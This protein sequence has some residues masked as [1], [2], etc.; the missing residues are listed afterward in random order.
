MRLYYSASDIFILPSRQ[1]N[2]PGTGIESHACGTPVVAFNTGGLPEIIDHRVT[3]A[4][5]KCF[6][7]KSLALEIAFVLECPERHASLKKASR[8]RAKLIWNQKRI[9]SMYYDLYSQ[10]VK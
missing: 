6:E 1:D 3:G 2:L 4:L 5:A 10:L 9:S 8:E 7:P